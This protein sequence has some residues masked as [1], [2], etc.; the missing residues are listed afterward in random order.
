MMVKSP[1]TRR[2]PADSDPLTVVQEVAYLE[3]GS[4]GCKALSDTVLQLEV[5]Q[6]PTLPSLPK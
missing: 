4:C 3:S 5:A 2:T 1:P 6:V